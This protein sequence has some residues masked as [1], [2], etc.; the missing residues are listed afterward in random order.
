M[1]NEEIIKQ[2][3]TN[4]NN[5]NPDLKLE[6]KEHTDTKILVPALLNEKGESI[7][8]IVSKEVEVSIFRYNKRIFTIQY[9]AGVPEYR[10]LAFERML[11]NIIATG[12]VTAL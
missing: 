4:L 5:L 1:N 10:E 7:N 11:H 12:L 6:L 2:A 3:I 8:E 9:F